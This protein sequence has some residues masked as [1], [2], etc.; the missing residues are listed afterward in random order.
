[1]FLVY[2]GLSL[3]F[4]YY[5]HEFNAVTT[6]H[7]EVLLQRGLYVSNIAVLVRA[8]VYLR[9][10]KYIG[11][12]TG[13]MISHRTSGKIDGT[14]YGQD[15]LAQ[16]LNIEDSMKKFEKEGS[17]SIFSRYFQTVALLDSSQFCATVDSLGLPLTASAAECL[18]PGRM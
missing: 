6:A 17:H 8:A 2:G 4:N 10:Q 3:Y 14:L 1:M 12:G 16:M 15:I 5:V 18:T 11:Y 9:S 13:M 7:Y